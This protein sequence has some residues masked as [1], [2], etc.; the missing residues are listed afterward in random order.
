ME[1]RDTD[2]Q[3]AIRG[4]GPFEAAAVEVEGDRVKKNGWY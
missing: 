3:C 1:G 4:T 2:K